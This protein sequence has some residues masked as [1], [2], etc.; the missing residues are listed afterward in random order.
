[1]DG[2]GWIVGEKARVND[3]DDQ[4][5][6]M[7]LA[8][9]KRLQ[10]CGYAFVTP[11]PATHARV[12]NRP[13]RQ[14]ATSLTDA[15][16]WSLPFEPGALPDDIVR[17]LDGAAV[18][19]RTGD[20]RLRSLVRVSTVRGLLFLHSAF[21][22]DDE[23]SVFLG[24][25]SYRFADLIAAELRDAP[26]PRRVVDIGSGA[27]VGLLTAG[28]LF[29]SAALV[30]TDVNAKALR[31]ARI[32]A[33]A[34]GLDMTAVETDG[35]EG[36]DDPIDL[37]LANPPYIIDPKGRAYRDG[38]AL[39]GGQVSL[40]MA[41]AAARRLAQGGRLILYTGSAIVRGRDELGE[42]LAKALAAER[43]ALSYRE[44]DPDVF[45]EELEQ[46]AY[47]DVDRIAIVA[48]VAVKGG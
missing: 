45:G 26:P 37:A 47:A 16:G 2:H 43:C 38:G 25:D 22:T 3:R 33:R 36:V 21:P 41:T 29:P 31:L 18:L 28:K 13:D 30:G 9:L 7:L 35:L 4:R 1:M 23:D 40:D 10:S 42:A 39:H 24:P 44:L 20:G 15:L 12:L 27:G 17:L 14:I 19:E 6:E 48:A 34:A 32:N 46:P 8:L 11:T 5:Q